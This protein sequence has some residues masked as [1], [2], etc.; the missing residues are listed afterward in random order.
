MTEFNPSESYSGLLKQA[1]ALFSL[2]RSKQE[3]ITLLQS[4]L[5]DLNRQLALVDRAALDAERNKNAML[6][7]SLLNAEERIAQMRRDGF[8]PGEKAGN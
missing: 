1:Y 3:Q 8:V 6:T 2:V 5:Q 7:E 4:Q